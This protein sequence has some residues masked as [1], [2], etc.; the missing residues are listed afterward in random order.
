MSV[1]APVV[2]SMVYIEM[3]LEPWFA[4]YANLPEGSTATE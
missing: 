1:K 4:T 3:L 2:A